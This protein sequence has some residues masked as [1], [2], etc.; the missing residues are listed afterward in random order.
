MDVD[1]PDASQKRPVPH[2][3]RTRGLP[4]R[5]QWKY[6]KKMLEGVTD[7]PAT[8]LRGLPYRVSLLHRHRAISW[9]ASGVA[10]LVEFQ[11]CRV[12]L[13]FDALL[14]SD[15]VLCEVSKQTIKPSCLCCQVSMKSNWRLYISFVRG[16]LLRVVLGRPMALQNRVNWGNGFAV[17]GANNK[18]EP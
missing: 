16:M 7:Q 5:N 15:A 8:F 6:L 13:K 17:G 11:G 12:G 1:V 18:T 14:R 10:S 4:E 2:R 9:Y 3:D